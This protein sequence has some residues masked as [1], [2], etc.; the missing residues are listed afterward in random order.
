MDHRVF[1]G[2]VE[3]SLHHIA[4]TAQLDDMAVPMLTVEFL[5]AILQQSAPE[6]FDRYFKAISD[7]YSNHVGLARGVPVNE[8]R[9]EL[10]DILILTNS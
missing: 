4:K 9:L 10:R 6:E 1:M 7:H 8:S 2:A 5:L 3:Q